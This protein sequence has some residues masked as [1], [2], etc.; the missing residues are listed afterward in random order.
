MIIGVGSMYSFRPIK[1]TEKILDNYKSYIL[2]TFHTDSEVYNN[3][4]EKLVNGEY[5]LLK[6]PYIQLT[7]NYKKGKSIRELTDSFLSTEFLKMNSKKFDSDMKLYVH[8]IEALEN[9]IVNDHSTVVSTGTGSGKTESFLLPIFNHLMKEIEDGSIKRPGV[10]A[11]IIYP[12]NA[13]VNDQIKRLKELLENYTQISFGFFTGETREITNEK[14]YKERFNSTPCKNEVYLLKEMRESPPHILITNYAMLEHIL[15]KPENAV[16]IF[17]PNSADLW[18]YIVLDEA[19]SYGGAKGTEVS[20]LLRRIRTTLNQ[21]IKFILTSATLGDENSNKDVAEFANALTGS[22]D[23][24][25]SDIIR[26]QIDPP[27]KPDNLIDLPLNAYHEILDSDFS[28]KVIEKYCGEIKNSDR[29]IVLGNQ[30]LKSR[31]FWKVRNSLKTVKP[32]TKVA[33]ETELE[34][35]KLVDFIDVASKAKGKNG[36]R[37]FDARYHTFIRSMSGVY[38]SLKPSNKISFDTCKTIFDKDFDEEFVSYQMSVCYN[39][40]AVFIP[41][42]KGENQTLK[43]V[44]DMMIDDEGNNNSSLYM[45]C[46]ESDIDTDDTDKLKDYYDLCSKCGMMV[47]HFSEGSRCECGEKYKNIVKEVVEDADSNR[48]CHCPRCGQVNNKFGIVRDFY[49]GSEASSAVIASSLF[50]EIPQP[51]PTESNPNPI[52]QFLLFSDSRRSASYA[53]INLGETHENILMHRMIVEVINDYP[54]EFE[55]GI[56]YDDLTGYLTESV[57]AVYN[58]SNSKEDTS[59]CER[60][61][62]LAIAAE[63][64]GSN[65]SKSLQFSGLFRFVTDIEGKFSPL[66]EEEYWNLFNQIIELIREKGSVG[67]PKNINPKTFNDKFPG[68]R[69]MVKTNE[70]KSRKGFQESV[71]RTKRMEKYLSAVIGSEN[72]SKFTELLFDQKCFEFNQSGTKNG[73]SLKLSSFYAERM[74]V[75]YYCPRCHK[76]FP[77]SVKNICPNCAQQCLEKIDADFKDSNN[78]YVKL[79]RELPLKPLLVKEHT[80]QLKKKL[81]SKYQDDFIHQHLNALSCSTTFEMGIDIGSLS[82]VLLRN[83]PPAPTNY[84]QRAGRAGR[85]VDSSS[86]IITFCKNTS[87]DGHYFSEP[88]LIINGRVETPKINVNNPKIAIRHIFATALSFYWKKMGT[89]AENAKAAMDSEYVLKF[90]DYIRSKPTALDLFLKNFL[91]TDYIR[92][93]KSDDLSI[94]IDNGGWIDSLIGDEDGRLIL[95]KNE[96]DEDIESLDVMKRGCADKEDYKGANRIKETID[97]LSNEDVLSFMSRG[98]IIPKYGFP[99]DTTYLKSATARYS[100]S[101]DDFE[102]QR[103]LTQAITE[104]APGCQVVANG[105]LITSYNLKKLKGR[106]WDRY[107]FV[108]CSKCNA[109]SIERFVNGDDRPKTV[110][111]SNP[112]CTAGEIIVKSKDCFIVPKF[113]FEYN[114]VEPAT[115]NKPRRSRG[116]TFEYKSNS[117]RSPIS[118]KVGNII[119]TLEHNIDDELIAKSNDSYWICENCGFG[120]KKL[121]KSHK[122]PWSDDTDCEN[123]HLSSYYLG[124]VFRTD[125][126]IIHFDEQGTLDE[127]GHLSVLYSLIEGLAVSFNIERGEI[128]GCLRSNGDMSYDYVLF[129]NTPGGA[130]YVKSINDKNL[131][132]IVNNSIKILS[133][134]NCGGPEGDCSCYGCLRNYSNQN[135]HEKLKRGLALNY[136]RMIE[137][138]FGA[139]Y[140]G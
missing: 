132:I 119:G 123:K 21:N 88:E 73:Y 86:Y 49:L 42:I 105:Q 104:Y 31:L 11:M 109:V 117:N 25:E 130:G 60:M 67:I 91:P 75:Y 59:K 76:R 83:V 51:R 74:D 138:G 111:C 108:R 48:L 39:C 120:S 114:R 64:I 44:S 133:S 139:R 70:D 113:G 128:S 107:A 66:N 93:Y 29:M 47:P 1:S 122:L 24:D 15:I 85:G 16:E 84:I 13:L 33:E 45:L 125:V 53:A 129:D 22:Y 35:D 98:N 127:N 43:Q 61:A 32:I 106:Q 96:Y 87:H 38:L 137:K 136:L 10:R 20:M 99:V 102:L 68:S 80:A 95:L 5:E 140:V 121:V 101:N 26:A 27:E 131:L 77:F 79:Y 94:D 36:E 3:Q 69:S 71:F 57:R 18:K 9:I 58:Y 134:C 37:I 78:H 52:K 89:T 2:S 110:C 63:A 115:I 81:L 40:N 41:G 82:V 100:Q 17:N 103:D 90:K 55:K 28:E 46:L 56:L 23:I 4:I 112:N 124:T 14:G 6:G 54:N 72:L 50:N 97:T 30:L 34:N 8:Q 135:H 118:F 19:H 7:D 126:A 116:K 65:S 62:A 12:M 92:T